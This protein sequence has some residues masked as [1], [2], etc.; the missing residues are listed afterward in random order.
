MPYRPDAA[1][2]LNDLAANVIPYISQVDLLV[3]KICV[4]S[5]RVDTDIDKKRND[6]DDAYFFLM[7]LTGPAGALNL[8]QSQ[9]VLIKGDVLADTLKHCRMG[10]SEAWWKAKLGL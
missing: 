8:T 4:C 9:K 1:V 7:Q 6:A 3:H 10:K 2:P 5:V